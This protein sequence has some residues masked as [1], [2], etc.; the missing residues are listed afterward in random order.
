[1]PGSQILKPQLGFELSLEAWTSFERG[2]AIA[3]QNPPPESS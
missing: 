1:M 2:K 3:A